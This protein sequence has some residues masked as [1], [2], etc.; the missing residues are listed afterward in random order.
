M[1]EEENNNKEEKFEEEAKK[2]EEKELE[3][4][5]IDPNQKVIGA[6]ITNEMKRAYIDYA[7]SV[8]VSRALPSVEDGL[9]PVHRRIL[10][11]MHELNLYPNKQTVKSAR[12]VGN[13]LGN[14]HPHGDIAV[15][16]A[17][18]RMAQDFSLRYP[19]IHGQG[20]FGS[21]DG[22]PAAAMRY[23]EA[24][25]AAI[26]EKLLEDLD[27]DTVN[28]IPN[29]DNSTKE[30]EVLPAKLPNLLINGSSG[31]A[32][33]M[34]TNIPPHNLTEVCEAIIECINKP[35]VA[36][37]KLAEIVKGPDFPT[38]GQISGNILEMYKTG[39]GKLIVRGK[40]SIENERGRESIIVTEIPYMV[41]KSDLIKEIAR[42]ASEKKLPDVTDIRDESAKG[43]VRIVI[44]LKKGADSKFTINRLYQY[45][46]LQDRFDVNMLAL[47]KG[48]PHVLN[49]KQIIEAYVN[50]RKDVV[51]RRSRFELKKAEERLEIVEGLLKAIK[52]IDNI[53]SLIKKSETASEAGE[54]LQK[55]FDLTKRQA[56]A[57]LEIRLQQ[58]TALEH[59]KLE[60]E[61]KELKERIQE[62][63]KI[64]SSM[65]EIL[66]IVK[67]EVN[68]IKR[69]FAD[70][71]RSQIMQRIAEISEKDLVQKKEVVVTITEKGYVKRIDLKTY[72]EQKRGGRGVIGS[73][74]STG[75]FIKQLLTCS[76]HDYLLFFTSK[77]RVYWLKAY[78]IPEGERYGKGRAIINLLNLKD[79][80]IASIIAVKKFEDFLIFVT[81][82]GI[83][84][85]LPL[86]ELSKPRSTGV[87]VMN[88]PITGEDILIYVQPIIEKQEVLLVTKDGQAIRFNSNEIRSMGRSSYGVTGIKLDKGDEVVS[89]EVLPTEKSKST[90]L[91]IT[92]KGY[93]KRSAI[94]DYRLT[95]RA[96]KGVINLRV[97]EKTGPVVTTVSA[98]DKDSIIVTTQKGM[99]IRTSVKALRIMGRAT[100]GVRIVKMQ[101]GDKVSDLVK[102]Q[103]IVEAE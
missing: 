101:D 80:T 97:S 10:Y 98:D 33:G 100:Q 35:D 87:R 76:T 30:P 71:R 86:S 95:G 11:A 53:I 51:T 25:L 94:D 7:M 54:S 90:I 36:I 22:D 2:V 102:V 59:S 26:S 74:L 21:L 43:K 9:K 13:V 40:T 67:K 65:H 47:V 91:T 41:N 28:F 64:L 66:N 84:K 8:I 60:K 55:K 72:K 82:K 93:G 58:L 57:I 4:D 75:D 45:T 79:E 27:K 3:K 44:E 5:V 6:E 31:I 85:R 17:L 56:Q 89:L 92:E 69:Q 1:A 62:L 16:D 12:I 99:V 63:K 103:E 19:L 32:V 39:K 29:F 15:Y 70:V 83:V 24:K 48:K 20:N 81:K 23:S 88:L 96:G 52:N 46:R 68:E 61:Q 50:H 73:D 77:G 49:L 37:E 42:L 34:A 78:Q 18:V 38:G 14:F